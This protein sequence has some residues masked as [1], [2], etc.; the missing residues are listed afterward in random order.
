MESEQGGG[1]KHASAFAEAPLL[2]LDTAT[3]ITLDRDEVDNVPA[4]PTTERLPADAGR[5]PF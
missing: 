5:F 2:S 1:M 4:L 3:P